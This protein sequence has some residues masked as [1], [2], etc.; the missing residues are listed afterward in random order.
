MPKPTTASKGKPTKDESPYKELVDLGE[1]IPDSSGKT[2]LKGR[3]VERRLDGVRLVDIRKYIE[4]PD[5]DKFSG[6]T[7][8]GISLTD[9]DQIDELIDMLTA[10]KEEFE[11]GSLAKTKKAEKAKKKA[12]K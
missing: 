10:A 1:I 2:R 11:S 5:P 3:I 8:D 4:N 9:V 7:R 6:F 12:K